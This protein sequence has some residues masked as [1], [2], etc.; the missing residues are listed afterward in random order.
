V[1]P[2]IYADASHGIH[3]D[4]KGHGG[5][6]I[7]LGSAPVYSKSYKLK[8]I[9]RSSSEAELVVLEEASTFTGWYKHLL[10]DL[11]IDVGPIPIY[12]D[13]KSTIILAAQGGS[14]QRTKHLMMK[15]FYVKE[16]ID[17][18]EACLRHLSTDKMVA[19]L[20]TKPLGR[21]SSQRHLATLS[22]ST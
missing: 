13:N 18:N 3:A 21:V 11:G 6:I 7:T 22:I 15:Q 16:R 2:A 1:Q 4:G 10:L 8:I 20:L 19:D 14:F 5:I 9:T 17:C 12:Q